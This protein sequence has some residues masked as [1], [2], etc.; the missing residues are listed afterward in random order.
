MMER[1][2]ELC[3]AI[4]KLFLSTIDANQGSNSEEVKHTMGLVKISLSLF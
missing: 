3:E 4:L 2:D 1:R